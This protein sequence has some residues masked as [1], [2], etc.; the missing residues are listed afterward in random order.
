MASPTKTATVKFTLAGALIHKITF[1]TGATAGNIAHEGP[2]TPN[3]VLFT[4]TG[5]I[6]NDNRV[7]AVSRSATNVNVDCEDDGNNTMEMVCVWF[8]VASG[9][10]NPP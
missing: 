7:T 1:T 10:L 4:D 6:D 2:T 3:L 8:D 5:A 9:G